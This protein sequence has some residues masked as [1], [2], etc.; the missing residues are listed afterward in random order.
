MT[1]KKGMA[2]GASAQVYDYIIAGG[3]TAGGVLAD[4]LTADG[5][6][7]VLLI[8]AGPWDSNPLYRVPIMG[9]HLYQWQYNN[10]NFQTEPEP[11]LNNRRI[12]WPRG[13]V[14]GGSSSMNG[15]IYTRGASEDYDRW[16]QAGLPQWSYD[17]VLPYFRK[18]ESYEG[19]RSDYRG[20]DGPIRVS[21]LDSEHPLFDA[22]IEAGQQA[23]LPYNPD[24][25]GADL[26]GVGR[27]DTNIAAG[28]R[29]STARAYLEPARGRDNLHV[30][31]GGLVERVLIEGRRAT[32]VEIRRGESVEAYRCG[33]EVILSGG[34]IGS[35]AALLHSGIGDPA[36]LAKV[37]IETR[38]ELKGV[39]RNLQDHLN[40]T[41]FYESLVPDLF[42]REARFDR[43]FG[44]LANAFLRKSGKGAI[45]PHNAGAFLKSD[46]AKVSPDLQ[47][48]YMPAGFN[49]RKVRWPLQALHG[50]TPYGF[51]G[52][53][54]HLHPHSRG[55]ISL[56]SA[57]ATR[58]PRIQG[59]YATEEADRIAL[60]AGFREL[61]RIF[62]QPAYDGIRGK[63]LL[64][65][66]DP[67]T[68]DEIDDWIAQNASTVFHPVGT[69][70]MGTDP[71]AVVDER[72]SVHG[73]AGLR[74]VD[75]SIMP[76]LVSANTHA[77]TIMIAERAAD[78]ILEDRAR[79]LALAS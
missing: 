41:H 2:G 19:E 33:G 37:G 9:V 43:A 21:R 34:A 62:A 67:R 72:L 71:M 17:K 26:E 36:E 65:A 56:Q 59:N 47:I 38:H 58:A 68:D 46:P 48:H 74:V 6:S 25:N 73:M 45:V 40:F 12:T 18:L 13:R 63:R 76:T 1:T 22:F 8:E 44:L 75:A 50:D 57:D 27:Y 54:C 35:P 42:F 3:G 7:R 30:V 28:Q 29:W 79:P 23:G 11:G 10:W 39:G 52:H 14:I 5:R 55:T 60:R 61:G 66:D 32:G 20:T 69:C 64:P 51:A 4:R 77:P 70:K 24:F 49:S 53:M 16:A 78:F 31:T 15:M